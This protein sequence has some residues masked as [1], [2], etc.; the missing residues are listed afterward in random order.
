MSNSAKTKQPKAGWTGLLLVGVLLLILAVLAVTTYQRLRLGRELMIQSLSH[1]GSL[2]V[3][4]LEGATRAGMRH[5][6]WR[7]ALLRYLVEETAQHP[8]VH[9]IA[10]L[11]PDGRL[12]AWGTN[13]EHGPEQGEPL[14]GLPPQLLRKVS[15]QE[16][17]SAFGPHEMVVAVSFDPFRR[18]RRPGRRLPNWAC[19]MS[20]EPDRGARPGPPGGRAGLQPPPPPGGMGMG[21]GMGMMEDDLTRAFAVVRL[22][23]AQYEKARQQA[24]RQSV[25]LAGLIFLGAGAVALGLWAAARRRT[26]EV[27]RL[28]REVAE[29]EHLAAVGR[30]AGSVAHEVRNP[31]SAL[32][33]LVQFL[34]KDAEPGSR[35][36]EYA[37]V[38]VSE[39]DRLERV[40]SS[41]LEYTRP[42]EPRRVSMDLAESLSGTV[43]IMRDDPRAQGVELNL[44]LAEGLPQVSADPDQV[45]QLVMNLLVNALEALDGKGAVTVSAGMRGGRVEVSIADDGPGLPEGEAEQVFDPF[46]STRQRGSGLGLAIARRIA[47]AHDGELSAANRPEGGAVFTLSLPPSKE[48]A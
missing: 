19:S 11:S 36:A 16:P 8:A 21:R 7:L 5:G 14:A 28:R 32:R 2:I 20:Q 12:L 31:L 41:L 33:G 1:T 39:V 26:S 18:F 17:F 45:R 27:E 42:R 29:S 15:D 44:E 9:S 10:I 6:A 25:L 13:H 48:E 3:Q 46:F 35:K 30:L 22:S 24:L 4:S 34:A 37:D 40:V 38:A 23:T 47:R 43:T